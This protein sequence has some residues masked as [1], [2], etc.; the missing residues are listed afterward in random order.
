MG[1]KAEKKMKKEEKK[2]KGK[3]EKKKRKRIK[4]TRLEKVKKEEK[5]KR[6][7]R[8]KAIRERF[9]CFLCLFSPK[10]NLPKVLSPNSTRVSSFFNTAL[11]LKPPERKI[12][13]GEEKEILKQKKMK[14]TSEKFSLSLHFLFPL[15]P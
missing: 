2:G 9:F 14:Q 4:G 11:C 1:G 15:P 12:T 5:R 13:K 7:T 8:K 6:K 10:K 3:S